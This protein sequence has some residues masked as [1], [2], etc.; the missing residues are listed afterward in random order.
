VSA[1]GCCE[2][3][4][5]GSGS[6]PLRARTGG[7]DSRPAKFPRRSFDVTGW[8][9][10][11]AILALLPKCPACLAAYVAIG[12][13]VGLSISTA[14]YLRM[15]LVVMCLISLA[16][17]AARPTRRLISRVFT[18]PARFGRPKPNRYSPPDPA[19]RLK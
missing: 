5:S 3:G 15:G 8:M 4:R 13:G 19:L 7:A 14:T 16:Y 2:V 9:V 18:S 17:L 1:H 6:E 10:P 12:T 11:A